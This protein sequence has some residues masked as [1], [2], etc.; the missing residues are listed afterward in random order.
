MGGSAS[1]APARGVGVVTAKQ[2]EEIHRQAYEEGF[3]Q[4]KQE[5]IEQARAEIGALTRALST[6]LNELDEVCLEEIVQLV[7]AVARGLVRRELRNDPGEIVAVVREAMAALPSSS[8]H[9]SLH[10]HPED[11]RIVRETLAAGD[12]DRHWKIVEDPTHAR[13]GCRVQTDVSSVDAGLE[14][15]LNAIVARLLGGHREED[16]GRSG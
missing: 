11:A 7:K 8:R 13:G 15:R 3:A 4:G 2:I 14:T 5:A 12:G 1:S 9:I 6:P 10:L 16:V